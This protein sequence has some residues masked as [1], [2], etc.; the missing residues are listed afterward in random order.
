MWAAVFTLLS[1]IHRQVSPK[2][3]HNCSNYQFDTHVLHGDVFRFSSLTCLRTQFWQQI[4]SHD[5]SREFSRAWYYAS[6]P[7]F[8]P[9]CFFPHIST[10][11]PL[12]HLAVHGYSCTKR[13]FRALC[14]AT[15]PTLIS[16]RLL[17]LRVPDEFWLV[18]TQ[19]TASDWLIKMILDLD[20]WHRETLF[21]CCNGFQILTILSF[22][23]TDWSSSA[24]FLAFWRSFWNW[25]KRD[26]D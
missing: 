18:Q 16:T 23:L 26:E 20:Q 12:P 5:S 14:Y 6:I 10:M 24:N 2:T 1:K 11:R 19:S 25:N 7:A 8:S 22:L 21:F 4:G 9:R 17:P 15:F 13:S 3:R